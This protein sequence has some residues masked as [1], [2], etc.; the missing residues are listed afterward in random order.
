M[1][2]LLSMRIYIYL[3]INISGLFISL[4]GP[5]NSL[6]IRDKYHTSTG[7]VVDV[8]YAQKTEANKKGQFDT[9]A[10]S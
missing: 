8:G 9:T 1:H 6:F 3:P 10:R 2:L 5:D 7:K 4:W